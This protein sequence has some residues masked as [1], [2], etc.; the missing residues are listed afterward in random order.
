M[1]CTSV[2]NGCMFTARSSTCSLAPSRA[3]VRTD[4][5]NLSAAAQAAARTRSLQLA[6][7]RDDFDCHVALLESRRDPRP[8]HAVKK[9]PEQWLSLVTAPIQGSTRGSLPSYR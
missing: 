3:S 2:L 4:A 9:P 1:C 8:D 6:R 7:L 5:W